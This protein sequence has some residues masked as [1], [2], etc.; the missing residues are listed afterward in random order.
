MDHRPAREI[1]DLRERA[2]RAERRDILRVVMS[3]GLALT[4]AGLSVG[5]L[6]ALAVNRTLSA[7]LYGIGPGD[8]ISLWASVAFVGVFGAVAALVPA[9]SAR[10][11]QRHV[12]S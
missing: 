4:G 6:A 11:A 5:L 12:L 9:I 7:F 10:V 2:E 3:E 8:P 1:E